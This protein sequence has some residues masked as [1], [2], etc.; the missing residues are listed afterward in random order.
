[1]SAIR[2]GRTSPFF[3]LHC[4]SFFLHHAELINITG[5]SYRMRD[6]QDQTNREGKKRRKSTES[7]EVQT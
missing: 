6:R 5:K 1:L 7:E 2:P 3:S 4:V